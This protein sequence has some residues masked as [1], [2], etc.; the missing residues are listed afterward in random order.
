VAQEHSYHALVTWTGSRHGPTASY[1]SYSREYRVKFAGKA[2]LTGSADPAFRGDPALPNPEDLLVAAL[3]ACHLLTYLALCARAGIRVLS[4]TDEASGRMA[5]DGAKIRFTEV[6]LHP[7]VVIGATDDLVRARELHD[8]AHAGCFIAN[9][10]AFPM[11]HEAVVVQADDSR[12][13]GVR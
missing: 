12:L 1:Q 4:Y 8:Q 10:I 5:S 2:E 9:S 7:R 11:R 3:S 6:V 13:E